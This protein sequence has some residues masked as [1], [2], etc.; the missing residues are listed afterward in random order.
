VRP[1]PSPAEL[2]VLLQAVHSTVDAA[3]VASSYPFDRFLKEAE[4]LLDGVIDPYVARI[5][6]IPG[7]PT[8]VMSALRGAQEC[9]RTAHGLVVQMLAMPENERVPL[10]KTTKEQVNQMRELVIQAQ[11]LSAPRSF[12]P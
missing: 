6:A 2:P 8:G 7:V 5:A 10:L 4:G 11:Q 1:L 3:R 9:G 12:R